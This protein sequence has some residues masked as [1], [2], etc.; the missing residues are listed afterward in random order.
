[1]TQDLK[2]T[3]TA[4]KSVVERFFAAKEGHDLESLAALFAQE[5]V[6]IFPLPASGAQED[7]FVYDGK[8]ATMAYQRRT[9]EAFSQL[10]MVDREMSISEDGGT[11]FMECRGDYITSDGR[12]YK[13]IYVFKFTIVDGKIRKVREYC[14]PVTYA[15]LANLPIA[16]SDERNRL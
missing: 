11:I 12:P 5:V 4:A 9:S 2:Q 7:W 8:E 1:M 16:A 10:R 3:V 6:Y 15:V 14:N 13:N